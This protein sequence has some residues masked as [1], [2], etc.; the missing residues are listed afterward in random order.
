MSFLAFDGQNTRTDHF[1]GRTEQ[2]FPACRTHALL[3][4]LSYSSNKR[5]E[6]DIEIFGGYG[7]GPVQVIEPSSTATIARFPPMISCNRRISAWITPTPARFRLATAPAGADTVPTGMSNRRTSRRPGR[8]PNVGRTLKVPARQLLQQRRSGPG[9]HPRHKDKTVN[10][11]DLF[12]KN[13]RLQS[14]IDP[15][16]LTG[17]TS[18]GFAGNMT[19]WAS[20]STTWS[21]NGN[22]YDIVRCATPTITTSRG[23]SRKTS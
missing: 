7:V 2:R 19:S 9:L 1:L 14:L 13:D 15:R 5:D 3:A 20:R 21:N 6:W 16:F 11:L 17:P 23:T 10:E 18:L 22:Y 8:R 4:D 12:L